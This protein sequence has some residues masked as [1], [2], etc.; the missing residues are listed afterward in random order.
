MIRMSAE[1]LGHPTI[2]PR[3]ES[4]HSYAPCQWDWMRGG[5]KSSSIYQ[6]SRGGLMEVTISRLYEWLSMRIAESEEFI[7]QIDFT[8]RNNYHLSSNCF[9]QFRNSNEQSS[10]L[11]C[12]GI[13]YITAIHSI[14]AIHSTDNS[15]SVN[16]HSHSLNQIILSQMHSWW[17]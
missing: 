3:P 6:T 9:Y 12:I 13:L 16:N 17:C 10:Y 5:I 8:V 1:G 7:F 15:H 2:N 14:K 11:I 4:N